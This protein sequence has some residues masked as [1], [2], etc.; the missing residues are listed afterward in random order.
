M[1]VI[2]TASVLLTSLI[3]QELPVSVQSSYI[4]K[5]NNSYSNFLFI[6]SAAIP[7]KYLLHIR[8]KYSGK[9]CH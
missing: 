1:A 3:W 5:V 6:C 8:R 4:K 2:L 9:V 7:E